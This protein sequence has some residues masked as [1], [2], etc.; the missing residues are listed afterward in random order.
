M[1]VNVDPSEV[2]LLL[3]TGL[4][5]LAMLRVAGHCLELYPRHLFQ[6]QYTPKPQLTASGL[7]QPQHLQH[8]HRHPSSL[9]YTGTVVQRSS[10]ILS[11]L[12]VSYAILAKV[13]LHA[14]ISIPM[15]RT[16]AG[17]IYTILKW[18]FC[19]RKLFRNNC[20]HTFFLCLWHR[21]RSTRQE[22]FAGE[23]LCGRFS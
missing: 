4:D 22:I 11:C 8:P 23:S 12:T 20:R 17:S 1:I 5:Y 18:R 9:S 7:V 3:L 10:R 6:H 13:L 15:V 16:F 14:M 19:F 2:R 21:W